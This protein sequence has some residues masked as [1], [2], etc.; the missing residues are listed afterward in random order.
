[1]S[2]KINFHEWNTNTIPEPPTLGPKGLTDA[3]IKACIGMAEANK[4][5]LKIAKEII[6]ATVVGVVQTAI[7]EVLPVAGPAMAMAQHGAALKSTMD[8]LDD[9]ADKVHYGK[10]SC[11][12]CEEVF[13]YIVTKKSSKV[14]RR[15]YRA[16]FGALTHT[17]ILLTI[18]EKGKGIYKAAIGTRK[19]NRKRHAAILWIAG[20]EGCPIAKQIVNVLLGSQ[21]K[22]LKAFGSY[23]GI[24][25]IMEKLSSK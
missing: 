8:H 15:G 17:S 1:M 6:C 10:C 7:T 22:M 3:K 12:K 16:T 11:G 13:D 24:I 9:L 19:V 25:A 4:D 21:S 14:A 2:E 18:A 20:K 5:Y 23:A